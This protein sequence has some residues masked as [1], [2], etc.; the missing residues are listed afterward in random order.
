MRDLSDGPRIFCCICVL[1]N[2]VNVLCVYM[3]N[4]YLITSRIRDLRE[5]WVTN[6]N[7]GFQK[8]CN[9]V[10][11]DERHKKFPFTSTCQGKGSNE[12]G[13][14]GRVGD[15]SRTCL[16][17]SIFLGCWHVLPP[18]VT[19]EVPITPTRRILL[20]TFRTRKEYIA[21]ESTRRHHFG[22]PHLWSNV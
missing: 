3:C 7:S 17:G 15:L 6:A 5:R 13:T 19:Q 2:R 14:H 10:I 1:N 20:C 16:S 21:N 12:N 9:T 11:V 18:I 22:I 8:M 4:N